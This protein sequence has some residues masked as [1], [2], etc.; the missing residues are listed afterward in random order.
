MEV[1]S[2][3]GGATLQEDLEVRWQ[4]VREQ[5]QFQVCPDCTKLENCKS[6]Y[7]CIKGKVSKNIYKERKCHYLKKTSQGY[8]VKIFDPENKV[9]TRI[10]NG[11][12]G[13]NKTFGPENKIETRV[14]SGEENLK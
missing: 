2:A 9:E 13:S 12:K 5:L 1:A 10:K 8:N 14:K 11:V 3:I 6:C 7:P 4:E